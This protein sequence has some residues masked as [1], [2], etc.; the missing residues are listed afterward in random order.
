MLWCHHCTFTSIIYSETFTDETAKGKKCE[1]EN[2]L[3][4]RSFN[5]TFYVSNDTDFCI[6]VSLY[7]CEFYGYLFRWA[8]KLRRTCVQIGT[9]FF[10][11]F[12]LMMS[13]V[14]WLDRQVGHMMEKNRIT[15]VT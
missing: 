5:L 15:D 3:I 6:Y 2:F 10:Y 13:L 14:T 4:G 9:S 7:M 8:A 1:R 11:G 12:V